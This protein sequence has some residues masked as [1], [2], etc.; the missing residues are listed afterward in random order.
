MI[1][2][3][4]L[5]IEIIFLLGVLLTVFISKNVFLKILIVIVL[6]LFVIK[7]LDDYK[8]I[9]QK[10][11]YVGYG[12]VSLLVLFIINEYI[13]NIYFVA[14]LICLVIIY[15]YLFK[16]LFNTTYG[17]V[18]KVTG[19]KVSIQILDPFYKTKNEL[20]LSF[21]GKVK[22]GDVAIIALTKF[23]INKKAIKIIKVVTEPKSLNKNVKKKK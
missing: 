18:T 20:V 11:L 22:K 16:V 12:F 9:Q 5:Y 23:P 19:R 4:I 14:A 1:D 17:K 3:N 7:E 10:Y 2:K 6:F 8:Y 13:V 15:L 21:S